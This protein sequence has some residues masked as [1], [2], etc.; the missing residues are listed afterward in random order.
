[1]PYEKGSFFNARLF[2]FTTGALLR[3][4]GQKT[5]KSINEMKDCVMMKDGKICDMKNHRT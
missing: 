4:Q 1:M 3:S 5:D 2:H